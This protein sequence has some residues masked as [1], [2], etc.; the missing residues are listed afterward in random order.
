MDLDLVGYMYGLLDPEE[1]ART[2]AALNADPA[3][4]ARLERLRANLAPME[5]VGAE[6]A[7]PAGL[8]DRTLALVAGHLRNGRPMPSRRP[9]LGAGQEPVFTPS[10]WR[11]ADALVA[12]CVLI[13]VGGL[14][15]SG[16]GRL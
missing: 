7:P 1:H 13:L 3:A 10:R 11:R 12:A 15:V 4:L 8:A 2:E 9:L 5:L 6:D 16:V 14:G